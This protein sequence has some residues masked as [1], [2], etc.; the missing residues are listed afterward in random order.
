[1]N[2]SE[3]RT[4]GAS[5]E[6]LRALLRSEAS[7]DVD[8]EDQ[9]VP[10]DADRLLKLSWVAAELAA[11]VDRAVSLGPLE[12]MNL[13]EFQF[14]DNPNALRTIRRSYTDFCLSLLASLENAESQR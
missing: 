9:G 1:M 10:L 12:L 6:Y 7:F 2:S 5:S 13:A 11:H 3:A 14:Q 4:L 8:R